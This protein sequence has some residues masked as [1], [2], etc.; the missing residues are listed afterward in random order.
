MYSASPSPFKCTSRVCAAAAAAADAASA[1][2]LLRRR[3]ALAHLGL[4]GGLCF[5]LPELGIVVHSTTT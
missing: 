5:I 4:S 3:G 1:R 2:M